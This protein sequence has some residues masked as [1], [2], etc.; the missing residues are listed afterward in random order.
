MK[1]SGRGLITGFKIG[2]HKFSK[3]LQLSEN[4]KCQKGYEKG[5]KPNTNKY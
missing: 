5:S 2:V 3:N 1:E 4:Y